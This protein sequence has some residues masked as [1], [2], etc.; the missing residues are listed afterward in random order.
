[1]TG[2]TCS[3]SR[4]GLETALP[5]LLKLSPFLSQWQVIEQ[6]ATADGW[7]PASYPYVLAEQERQQRHRVR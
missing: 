5:T 1:M 3:P 4:P 7:L 2:W 6:Q